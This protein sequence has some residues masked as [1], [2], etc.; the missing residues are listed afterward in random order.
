MK[1]GSNIIAK[2]NIDNDH[3]PKNK[4]RKVCIILF[5][6]LFVLTFTPKMLMRTRLGSDD[7]S[8]VSHAFTIALDGDLDYTNET[9]Y[10]WNKN[11]TIA[12][13]GIGS[14]AMASVFVFPMSLLDRLWDHPVIKNHKDFY[15]S[16]SFFGF[17]LAA[18]L[19]FLF[20]IYIYW[21][22]FKLIWLEMDKLWLVPLLV[23]S[24]GVPH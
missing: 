23:F 10:T 21:K 5:T 14:G 17:L 7:A 12:G 3:I 6:L 9:F 24:S 11:R 15:G 19:Y 20:A 22:T 4:N 8:Y 13:H 16:W 18:N 2:D 1:N